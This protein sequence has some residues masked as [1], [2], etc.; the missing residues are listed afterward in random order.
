MRL[1][2]TARAAGPVGPVTPCGMNRGSMIDAMNRTVINGMAR[3][4]SMNMTQSV[5]MTGRSDCRPSARRIP[6]GMEQ[7]MPTNEM[8]SVTSRPPHCSVGT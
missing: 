8:I 1:P 3:H 7:M 2:R 5:L 6:N 4:S